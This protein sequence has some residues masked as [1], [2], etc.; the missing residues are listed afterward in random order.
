MLRVQLGLGLLLATWCWEAQVRAGEWQPIAV[1]SLAPLEELNQDLADVGTMLDRPDIVPNVL[2]AIARRS[3]AERLDGWDA[4]RRWGVVVHTNGLAVTAVLALPVTDLPTLLEAAAPAIGTAEPLAG[5]V[6]RI[7]KGEG[8]FYV[9]A[10]EGWAY[11]A[12]TAD[13]FKRLPSPVALEAEGDDPADV[14]LTLYPQRL[15]EAYRTMAVD[16]VQAAMREG[17]PGV[18]AQSDPAP[19]GESPALRLLDRGLT[20]VACV[21]LGWSLEAAKGRGAIQV[22]VEPLAGSPLAAEIAALADGHA[23]GA[24]AKEAAERL[25][26]QAADRVADGSAT[27]VLAYLAAALAA[28]DGRLSTAGEVRRGELVLRVEAGQGTLR[29][30]VLALSVG[31]LRLLN[32]GP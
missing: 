6:T 19:Q 25:V 16:S 3:G 11:V 29:T 1:L 7:G 4:T 26:G 2:Q 20:E 12:Q 15:P 10:R 21:T 32:A 13:D 30:G 17:V 23:D 8:T 18:A 24:W 28:G 22:T 27:A 9:A 31:L 5:G 14:L